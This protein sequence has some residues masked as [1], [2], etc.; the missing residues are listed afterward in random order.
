MSKFQ[1]PTTGD[2]YCNGNLILSSPSPTWFQPPTTGDG[3]CNE[4]RYKGMEGRKG[5]FQPPT[6][7]DGY[8]NLYYPHNLVPSPPS[9]QPPTTG[10]GYC[11]PP[12]I[13]V[14]W[15]SMFCFNPLQPG[16]G[17]VINM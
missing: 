8:C 5:Q 6:T 7:G 15:S 10:D 9:F 16:M 17:T 14:S 11:N 2:G 12:N 4:R 1:P 13:T 3:Y